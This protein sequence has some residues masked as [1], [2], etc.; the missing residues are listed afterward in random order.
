[1]NKFDEDLM[2]IFSTNVDI[3][4]SFT[5]SIHNAFTPKKKVKNKYFTIKNIAATLLIIAALG[6]VTPNIYAAIKWN[7]VYKE[8]ENRQVQYGS[9]KVRE[10]AEEGYEE[11]ID[12]E[13][14]Y[15][16]NIGIKLNSL[17]ITD[18]YFSMNLDFQFDPN[19]QINTDTF[20][21]GYA[22]YD[23]NNNI[24]ALFP[25]SGEKDLYRNYTKAFYQELNIDIKN[26]KPLAYTNSGRGMLTSKDGHLIYNRVFNSFLGFPKSKKIYIRVFDIGY[27]LISYDDT[28]HKILDYKD[29][30]LS[31]AEWI[32]EVDVPEKF[33]ERE[34]SSLELAEQ[35]PGFTVHK[36]E[37][38][39]TGL[40]L[41]AE[42]DEFIDLLMQGKNMDIE[43][44]QNLINETLFITDED[45][46]VYLSNKNL[47]T[48]GGNSTFHAYFDINKND[49]AKKL[50]LNFK[51]NGETYKVNIVQ[52]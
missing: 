43:D 17:M 12:M 5:N 13:Y 36:L 15:Q 8:F 35:I 14:V 40:T 41:V 48:A 26:N 19:V 22:V 33:Y 47:G 24:Y 23:E 45:G 29:V 49:L 1:M 51:I 18:D 9:A 34:T 28:T 50:Y 44:F 27:Y 2:R 16:D 46:N 42:M 31:D 3:P 37:I 4:Q 39:D 32:L 38:T 52:K 21:F 30:Y 20:T 25:R 10:I 7:I 6:I 11:N